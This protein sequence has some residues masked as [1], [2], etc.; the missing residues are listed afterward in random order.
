MG[1]VYLQKKPRNIGGV[2]FVS[3]LPGCRN[4]NNLALLAERVEGNYRVFLVDYAAILGRDYPNLRRKAK[5][6]GKAIK[7]LAGNKKI[8]EL[9]RYGIDLVS[10]LNNLKSVSIHDT[11]DCISSGIPLNVWLGK[12]LAERLDSVVFVEPKIL[13]FEGM[14]YDLL[15]SPSDES[16]ILLVE[17]KRTYKRLRKSRIDS[18]CLLQLVKFIELV[19]PYYNTQIISFLLVFLTS[20]IPSREVSN[21][22]DYLSRALTD[23]LRTIFRVK[24]VTIWAG[25]DENID[26]LYRRIN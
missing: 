18:E 7:F 23:K 19:V 8:V 3:S 20:N 16:Y 14:Q 5:S 10:F 24:R 4:I 26:E 11:L 12:K 15:L 22:C 21:Y 13:E 25:I 1:H 2:K 17:V 9:K 6:R